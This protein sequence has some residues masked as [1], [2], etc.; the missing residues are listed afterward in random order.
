MNLPTQLICLPSAAAS[1]LPIATRSILS[2]LITT[3]AFGKTLPS[4]GLITVAPTSAIFSARAGL[5]A[6]KIEKTPTPTQLRTRFVPDAR[7][8]RPKSNIKHL[9]SNIGSFFR[10]GHHFLGGLEADFRMRAVGKGFLG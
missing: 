10:F 6:S 7:A 8:H 4:A 2:P 5:I 9:T 1:C 3:V